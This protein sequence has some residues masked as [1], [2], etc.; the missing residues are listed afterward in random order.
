MF[1]IWLQDSFINRPDDDSDDAPKTK[2][3]K[4]EPVKWQVMHEQYYKSSGMPWPPKRLLCGSGERESEIVFFY[5]STMSCSAELVLDVS[6]M[7]NR[8]PTALGGEAPALTGD[9]YVDDNVSF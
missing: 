7:W 2:K 1:Y 6:Q 3:A 4:G 9:C 5:M 8:L